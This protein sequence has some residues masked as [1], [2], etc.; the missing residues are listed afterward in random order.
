[1]PAPHEMQPLAHAL[2]PLA[3]AIPVLETDRLRLRAMKLADLPL[4]EAINES[5]KDRSLRSTDTWSDFVQMSATWVFRGHGWWTVDDDAGAVGFVG[6]GFEPGDQAPELGYLLD[7][8]A[9]GKGYATEAA[10]AARDCARDLLRLPE[11]VSYISETNA[12]SQNV[13]RK[14]GA[15]R[16][17][18]AEKALVDEDTTQVWRHWGKTND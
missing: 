10:Q 3:A 1:M 18:E 2:P 12:A 6:L 4:L 8:P 11:L 5:L 7:A 13:A 17:A 9:R 16:D 15:V 14:L